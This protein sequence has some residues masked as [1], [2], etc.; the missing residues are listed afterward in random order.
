MSVAIATEGK[1]YF[2]AVGMNR[3]SDTIILLCAYFCFCCLF[4]VTLLALSIYTRPK[5]ND[6]AVS[7]TKIYK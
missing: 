5:N 4:I 7:N 2:R 1:L 3:L 6:F